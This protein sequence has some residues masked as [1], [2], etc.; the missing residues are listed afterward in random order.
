MLII[1][2]M[3]ICILYHMIPKIPIL[4]YCRIFEGTSENVRA[5]FM[6]A[7]QVSCDDCISTVFHSAGVVRR[8]TMSAKQTS[9][10]HGLAGRQG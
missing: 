7:T 3:F 10:V 1:L 2:L 5:C 9:T 4:D 8:R 6:P